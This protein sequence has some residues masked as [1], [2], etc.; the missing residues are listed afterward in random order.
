[1]GACVPSFLPLRKGAPPPA[2]SGT[3]TP[4]TQTT[5]DAQAQ[6]RKATW[7]LPSMLTGCP[8]PA[9]A[10]RST[11]FFALCIRSVEARTCLGDAFWACLRC[12]AGVRK[13]FRNTPARPQVPTCGFF[14]AEGTPPRPCRPASMIPASCVLGHKPAAVGQAVRRR[15]VAQVT[16]GTTRHAGCVRDWQAGKWRGVVAEGVG[17]A[18]PDARQCPQGVAGMRLPRTG[19]GGPCPPSGRWCMSKNLTWMRACSPPDAA[20]SPCP[21]AAVPRGVDSFF[22]GQGRVPGG[23]VR[24]LRVPP[25]KRK[26]C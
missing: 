5:Q 23:M 6:P 1:M 25:D 19:A 14:A 20:T 21:G 17:I 9:R 15:R 10:E 8:P 7:P 26:V 12:P 11:A 13:P 3:G 16:L 2:L 18:S 22:S 4:P 24:R